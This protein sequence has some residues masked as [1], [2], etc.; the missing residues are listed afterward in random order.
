MKE[1]ETMN[2]TQT[3]AAI[4]ST[5]KTEDRREAAIELEAKW[6]EHLDK[7]ISNGAV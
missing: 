3:I 7:A 2:T 6:T 4:E 5:P 1:N